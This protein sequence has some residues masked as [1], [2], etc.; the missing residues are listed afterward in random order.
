MKVHIV[1]PFVLSPL[2]SLITF[3]AAPPNR[4][5]LPAGHPN[6]QEMEAQRP[7][8]TGAVDMAA[9]HMTPEAALFEFKNTAE[10]LDVDA[11]RALPVHHNG[12]LK[13]LET[14]ARETV[15]FVSGSYSIFGLD[16]LQ[17]YLAMTLSTATP[18]LEMIE[19]RDVNLRTELGFKRERRRVSLFELEASP[20]ESMARPLITKQEQGS[21][22]ITPREKKV[23]ET[24]QQMTL[25][26]ALVDG[27]HFL[28]SIDFAS[29]V[30]SDDG[31]AQA[32]PHVGSAVQE[33]ENFLR[34]IASGGSV[35][36]AAPKLKA[37]V[38]AQPLPDLFVAQTT[39][40]EREVMF[41]HLRIFFWAA[42]LAFLSG[43]VLLVRVN[44]K[45]LPKKLVLAMMILPILFTAT[46]F[47]IRVSITGFAPVTNMYGTMIWVSQGVLLFGTLLFALYSNQVLAGL[48]LVASGLIL[49]LTDNIPLVLSP[50]LD[51]IVAVLRSNYWL[52]IHV[53]TITISYAAFTISMVLGNMALVRKATRVND[54]PAFYKQYAHYAYR[55]IQLGVFLITTGIILG[56]IWADYSWGRFWGWDPKE[57]WALIA[58]VGFIAILHARHIGWLRDFGTLAAA[59]VAYLLVIM[60]WYGVNFILAAGL[61]SYGFSSGGALVVAIFVGLQAVLFA[62]ALFRY[63]RSQMVIQ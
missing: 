19:I 14:L 16:P 25:A 5:N 45:P 56:G 4:S 3:A 20:L 47:G 29:L 23:I 55:V 52:T 33:G 63:W 22:S 44:R 34:S 54:D 49:F 1:V 11:V 50:D 53:L 18:S 46:G 6:I 35:S 28:S 57:T 32:N 41:N 58:D 31:S 8:D 62:F 40:L 15:L 59:P 7:S 37:A 21:K 9:S 2:V 39:T 26:R 13:P 60:A 38:L 17:T 12:R 30:R 27:A 42:L 48:L 51:P 43:V 61:H 10:R 24:Y 36:E